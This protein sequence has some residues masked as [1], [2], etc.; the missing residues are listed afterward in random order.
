M[1]RAQGRGWLIGGLP[2]CC[3]LTFSLPGDPLAPLT[4]PPL[5]GFYKNISGF[6]FK[7][8][9]VSFEKCPSVQSAFS[10]SLVGY[11]FFR[12]KK[13][14]LYSKFFTFLKPKKTFLGNFWTPLIFEQKARKNIFDSQ[15]FFINRPLGPHTSSGRATVPA[16][17]CAN[18]PLVWARL[19]K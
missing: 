16:R 12:Q 1:E 2:L 19:L 9:T 7:K 3:L 14:I 15:F 4:S 11:F 13:W 6:F 10:V 18:H 8:N 17:Q 5:R